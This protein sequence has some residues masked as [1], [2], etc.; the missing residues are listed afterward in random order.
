[1][2]GKKA[3]R[4]TDRCA[5]K[6]TAIITGSPD[7]IVG[8][9]LAAR[10]GDHTTPC[11]ICM[12]PTPGLI[13]KAST[14][15]FINKMPAARVDDLVFCGIGLTPPLPG[16]FHMPVS[17][18]SVK[19]EDNYVEAVFS[20]D[21]SIIHDPPKDPKPPPPERRPLQRFLQGLSLHLDI[22]MRIGIT[23]MF[24]GP[25]LIESGCSDV[26]IGG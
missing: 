4:L 5:H 19:T 15:V 8:S 17:G 7:T 1:V 10:L 20:D 3:A 24:A 25:N 2:A 23:A 21:S 22:G 26:F 16:G 13:V 6:V 14:S 18:Y 9:L 12:V 11:P